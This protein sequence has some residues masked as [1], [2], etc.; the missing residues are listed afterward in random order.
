VIKVGTVTEL[1]AVKES[2]PPEIRREVHRIVRILDQEYGASRD[3]DHSD[4]GVVLIAQTVEDI[5]EVNK[6][7]NGILQ[8]PPEQVNLLQTEP[9]YLNALYL[10][11][12]EYSINILLPLSIAPAERLIE[13]E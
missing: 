3:I 2:L 6:S 12:N 9:P 13:I 8:R 5:V 7:Y 1:E 10:T 4:G 11:N